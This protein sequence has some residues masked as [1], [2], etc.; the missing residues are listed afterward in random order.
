M[1][2]LGLELTRSR[3]GSWNSSPHNYNNNN[4]YVWEL[5]NACCMYVYMCVCNCLATKIFCRQIIGYRMSVGDCRVAWSW[6]GVMG[7]QIIYMKLIGGCTQP[8]TLRALSVT[9]S[10][11][12]H[13]VSTK[14]VHVFWCGYKLKIHRTNKIRTHLELD[15]AHLHGCIIWG[16]NPDVQLS[17][18]FHKAESVHPWLSVDQEE[19][20]EGEHLHSTD[21]NYYQH[22]TTNL[23]LLWSPPM[24]QQHPRLP[25]LANSDSTNT[26]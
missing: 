11:T 23:Q 14:M 7:K 1:T 4:N 17:L 9:Y 16:R 19:E 24:L 13:H 10:A 26:Q 20:E 21:N 6:K 5:I 18:P 12:P 15:T 25:W 2:R 3:P 8:C 22:S